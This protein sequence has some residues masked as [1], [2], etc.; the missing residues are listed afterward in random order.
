MERR[1]AGGVLSHWLPV[2]GY[3]ALIL[4]L[5]AQ[6]RLRSPLGFQNGDKLLHL[7]EYAVLGVLLV[8]ALART[9]PGWS[10]QRT[11][12]VA[13]VAG[14]VV[15]AGDELLQSVIPGRDAT[16]LDWYADGFGLVVAQLAWLAFTRDRVP[17]A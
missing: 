13:L 5:S 8:R 10:L 15:G 4:T 3:V 2:V 11:S 17:G 6:S 9:W 14:L 1:G 7:L 16:V 12:C